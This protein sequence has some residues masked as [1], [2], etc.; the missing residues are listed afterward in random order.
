MTG[1]QTIAGVI[2]GL[3]L[4]AGLLLAACQPTPSPP[5][6]PV[7]TAPPAQATTAGA[8]ATQ[9]TSVS[10]AAQPAAGQTAGGA[11]IRI[12]FISGMSGIYAGLG[13]TQSRG[14][15][16]AVDEI[17]TLLGRPLEWIARDDKLDPGE[18]AKQAEELVQTEKVEILSGCVSAATTLAV[19]EVAKRARVL[20]LGTCQT[21]SLNDAAKDFSEY[22]FHL[23]LTPWANQ[24]MVLP[25]I[26]QNLGKKIYVFAAD[27]AWGS[28]NLESV[29]AWLA[30]QPGVTLVGQSKAPLNT[31]DFTTFIPQIRASSPE[32]VIAVNAGA[33]QAN[34]L[35]QATQFGLS[36]D[37]KIFSPVVD[38]P[39]DKENGQ[40]NIIEHYGGANFYWEIQSKLPSAQKFVDAYQKK[41][42]EMPSGYASYQ[43]DATK[44]WAAAV[45]KAG[46][47]DPQ[48]VGA[49]L[50]GME[51]DYS[52][53][54]STIRKCD[55][56]LI[57]PVHITKGRQTA[58]GEFGYRDVLSTVDGDPKYQR[59]CEELGLGGR[60]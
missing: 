19:N 11:S 18:A 40:Q 38:T 5:A 17:K 13:Q 56:Q 50:E 46:S 55:H 49:A 35:K 9:P 7:A 26:T 30:K 10:Q 53:G 58:T 28:D 52:S 48:K 47:L 14:G 12:G 44:A 34:F 16:L 36:K 57:H 37:S 42:N 31:K 60:Q 39:F 51:F 23:A 22:T 8:P 33:D 15:E 3:V 45:E 41:F 21:N 6:A 4:A 2:R 32:V 25:W 24:Q 59:S 20:Y 1:Q 54:K 27:Y 43:Y 29:S